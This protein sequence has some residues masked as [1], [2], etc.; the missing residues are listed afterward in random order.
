MKDE[1]GIDVNGQ[2]VKIEK[3]TIIKAIKMS[4]S[5]KAGMMPNYLKMEQ[6]NCIIIMIIINQC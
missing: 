4:K 3:I 2:Q 1:V 6:I 5:D